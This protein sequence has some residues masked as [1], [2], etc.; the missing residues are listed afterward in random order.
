[1]GVLDIYVLVILVIKNDLCTHLRNWHYYSKMTSSSKKRPRSE[2]IGKDSVE[3]P[4]SILPTSNNDGDTIN[5]GQDAKL[6]WE[7]LCVTYQRL[8]LA[9]AV[10]EK[11]SDSQIREPDA[12][13]GKLLKALNEEVIMLSFVKSQLEEAM[14]KYFSEEITLPKTASEQLPSSLMDV[15]AAT[16]TNTFPL[17][18]LV[19]P[20]TMPPEATQPEDPLGLSNDQEQQDSIVK[21]IVDVLGTGSVITEMGNEEKKEVTVIPDTPTAP[22][23][24]T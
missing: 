11:M 7:K 23:A 13:K 15:A 20:V 19:T 12:T 5:R 10:Q 21:E 14:M 17:T 8:L 3:E 6:M 18:N 9:K 16:A 2:I 22:T 4:Q 1:M 24:S